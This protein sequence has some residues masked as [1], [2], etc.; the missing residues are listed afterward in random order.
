FVVIKVTFYACF[1][2]I[3]CANH[4]LDTQILEPLSEVLGEIT[5][6]WIVTRQ[7]HSLATEYIGVVLQ[8]RVHLAL[9]V[10]PLRVKLILFRAFCIVKVVVRYTPVSLNNG[11]NMSDKDTFVYLLV[12]L[13][14][15]HQGASYIPTLL[16]ACSFH[17]L[18][19]S[20]SS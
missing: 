5:P 16:N 14:I 6:A 1:L 12:H 7:Q 17:Y 13:S 3:A 15:F 11:V 2:C 10:D 18:H 8:I 4:L 20:C 9:D 19:T